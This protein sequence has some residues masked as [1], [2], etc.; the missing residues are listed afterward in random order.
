MSSGNTSTARS[1]AVFF[2]F[3]KKPMAR[4]AQTLCCTVRRRLLLCHALMMNSVSCRL[5]TCAGLMYLA[6]YRLT[7]TEGHQQVKP[8]SLNATTQQLP[9]RGDDLRL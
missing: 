6:V 3:V 9:C 4:Y 2:I 5:R 1:E 8:R 7:F